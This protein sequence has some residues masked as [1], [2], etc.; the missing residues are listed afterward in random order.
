MTNRKKPSSTPKSP[1]YTD[2]QI[3]AKEVH[4]LNSELAYAL[5]VARLADLLLNALL[6]GKSR[7]P[8]HQGAYPCG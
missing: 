6:L 3:L 8:D 1:W 5:D 2:A 4:E 7:P